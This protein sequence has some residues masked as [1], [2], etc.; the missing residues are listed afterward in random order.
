MNVVKLQS[1]VVIYVINLQCLF[2]ITIFKIFYI[3]HNLKV[4]KIKKYTK[5]FLFPKSTRLF[6]DTT[7]SEIQKTTQIPQTITYI[8]Q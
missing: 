8:Q 6:I 2:V 1:K 4:S 5:T 7:I 3:S